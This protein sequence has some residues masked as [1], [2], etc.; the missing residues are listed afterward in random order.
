MSGEEFEP[1]II[2]FCCNW[3]SYAG[4]D[5]AGTSRIQYPPNVRIIRVM[6]T[7]MVDESYILKALAEGA[8]GVLVAG[9]HPGDC[10]YVSGNLKAE[11]EIEKT[12][13]LLD[14]IGIGSNRLRLEWISASEGEKFANVIKDFVEQ[15][16][17]L[18][19]SPLRHK[20]QEKGEDP[21]EEEAS[22]QEEQKPPP[23]PTGIEIP[24]DSFV[25][26]LVYSDFLWRCLGCYLCHTRCPTN[27]VNSEFMKPLRGL[28]PKDEADLYCAH[29]AVPLMI[30]RMLTSPAL[31]PNRMGWVPSD[32]KIAEKG[33]ILYFVGCAP[34]YDAEF[35][36]L[37]LGETQIAEA[38][39]RILN[40]L[41]IEPVVLPE[42]RCCGHDLLWTGDYENFEKL[43]KMNVDMIK[44]AGA[45]TVITTCPECYRTIKID[46]AELFGDLDFEVIHLSEFLTK[47][48][49][50]GKLQFTNTLN[51]KVTYH[52]PCRLGR[53]LGVYDPPRKLITSIPGVELVEMER[54]RENSACCGVSSWLLCG[55]EA[56]KMQ[57]D[58]LREAK[59]TG[60]AKL[61]AGCHKCRIHF[62]CTQNEKV[63]E[64]FEDVKELEVVELTQL[65][66]E[67]LGIK[68]QPPTVS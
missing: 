40:K 50:E 42:E 14:V 8:D 31:K 2:A 67:A 7:G 34:Y 51:L 55:E 58:R 24:K 17:K 64:E 13:K 33:E 46:Y 15:L 36:D 53:H 35:N 65:V 54:V 27:A 22:P 20:E 12:K 59:N 56:K 47:M 18:G 1:K 62:I 30:A 25:G 23:P 3:C 66:A 38:T 61:V 21:P 57:L 39:I 19:P 10:H 26:R 6:C 63:P 49:D 52:D 28:I 5:L 60:A 4:A 48:L 16:K 32:V 37:P 11:K 44:K 29:G 9:C 43:A 41:G 45:T 68:L